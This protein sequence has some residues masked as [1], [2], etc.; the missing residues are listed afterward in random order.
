MN[1][2]DFI[3]I[4]AGA[5]GCVLAARLSTDPAN[6]VLLVE[7]GPDMAP[8]AEPPDVRDPFPGALGG[9]EFTWPGLSAEVFAASS[10]RAAVRR[11]FIQGKVVGG[12][13]TINGMMAQRGLPSDYDS[14]EAR[15]AEGW[16]WRGVLPYFNALEDDQDFRGPLHGTSGPIP[17][18]REKKADWAPFAKAVTEAMLTQGHRYFDD[19]NA[20][21][22]DGV[23][24]VPLNNLPNRRV[25]ASMGYLDAATRARPNLTILP[26][27]AATRLICEGR[28]V[29]G[30]EVAGAGG[31]L[32]LRARETIVCAG[33]VHSAAL[34]LRSG[35][36][37]SAELA[38][39][40]IPVVADRPG[41]GKNLL[42]HLMI[43]VATHL[44]RHA[45]QPRRCASWAFTVLRY[46]SGV[47]GCPQGDMQIFPINR[48]AWH[49]LGRRIGAMGLCLYKPFSVGS[50][51]LS[52]ADPRTPPDIRFNMLADE[53]DVSRLID[54]LRR[55]FDLL[56]DPQVARHRNDVFMPNKAAAGRLATRTTM[57][58]VKTALI[59]AVFG[60]APWLRRALLGAS[61]VQPA[62]LRDDEAALRRIVRDATAHVHHVCGTCRI[63]APQDTLAVVDPQCRVY[64]V[65]GLRVADTSVMPANISANTHLAAMMIG[66][67]AAAMVLERP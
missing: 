1:D 17:I 16:G 31:P 43:H 63:G 33:A 15:G 20:D 50:V 35:I 38:A 18:R 10:E 49:S 46:S 42:N 66:E 13:S 39:L 62:A 2:H 23:S 55:V 3:V 61:V 47:E 65:D 19:F 58:R 29:I 28:K 51:T 59:S 48:T 57:N 34:L 36:G 21:F 30:V 7:A 25:S 41:V 45:M 22:G 67:K 37:P 54:G 14:W 53:R 32:L 9:A 6:R 24:P 5:A 8:G 26:D 4:G 11:N 60:A 52:S 27:T 40:G 64:G 12:S 56:A 44:P